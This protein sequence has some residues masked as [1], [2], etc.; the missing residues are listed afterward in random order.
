MTPGERAIFRHSKVVRISIP[1][2]KESRRRWWVKRS[3]STSGTGSR[4]FGKS[5]ERIRCRPGVGKA[6]QVIDRR[7][8]APTGAVAQRLVAQAGQ[9]ALLQP[10]ATRS[11]PTWA[12]AWASPAGLTRQR[13]VP[14]RSSRNSPSAPTM[15]NQKL[16]QVRLMVEAINS[17]PG[18]RWATAW[19]TKAAARPGP[20][21]RASASPASPA[22][23]QQSRAHPAASGR[24]P[25]AHESAALPT[26][27]PGPAPARQPGK[28]RCRSRHRHRRPAAAGSA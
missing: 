11:N 25:A 2:P 19:A 8:A 28:T 16:R 26:P 4:V 12:I 6:G 24:R 20:A 10:A 18:A 15:L 23:A 9:R 13:C 5:G 1:P 22:R 27:D 14:S 17:P 3:P 21:G 7:T